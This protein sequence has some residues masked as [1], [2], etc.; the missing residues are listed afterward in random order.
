MSKR[1]FT[2]EQVTTLLQNKHIKTCSVKSISYHGDFKILAI[3]RYNQEG[4]LPS[5]I[6]KDAGFDLTLIGRDIPH[7]CLVSWQRVFKKQGEAG[8]AKE[9]RGGPGRRKSQKNLSDQEKLKYYEAQIAYLKAENAFLA[10]L[11]KQR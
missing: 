7:Q 4:I 11:R 8:F 10:K 3:R 5:Q 9:T 1:I 2:T 6:F